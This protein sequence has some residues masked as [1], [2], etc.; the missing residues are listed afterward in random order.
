MGKQ[1]TLGEAV[2]RMVPTAP[3]PLAG[4]PRRCCARTGLDAPGGLRR[5]TLEDGRHR[6]PPPLSRPRRLRLP[7]PRCWRAGFAVQVHF[8]RHY[9][10][11]DPVRRPRGVLHGRPA[12]SRTLRALASSEGPRAAFESVRGLAL[13]AGRGDRVR[14]P[15]RAAARATSAFFRLVMAA[16]NTLAMLGCFLLGPPALAGTF[17]GGLR[18][19]PRRGL[20]DLLRAD[21]PPLPRSRHGM[22]VRVGGG[23]RWPSA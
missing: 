13:P 9:P 19:G 16:F 5:P 18:A 11:A 23:S 14:G 10:A 15:G 7:W 8:L 17:A 20:P 22:P 4:R 12:L 1:T 21:G 3:G 2:T 6:P